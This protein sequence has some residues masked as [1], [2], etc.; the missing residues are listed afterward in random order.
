M[1]T[2]RRYEYK[3]AGFPNMRD[4]KAKETKN[5]TYKVYPWKVYGV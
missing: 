2:K 4:R 3:N 1:H 5:K